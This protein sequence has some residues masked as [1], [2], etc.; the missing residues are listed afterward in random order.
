MKPFYGINFT[1]YQVAVAKKKANVAGHKF[2]S[3]E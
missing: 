1:I 3:N 2:K